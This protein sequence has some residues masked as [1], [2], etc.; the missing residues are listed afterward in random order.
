VEIPSALQSGEG[1]CQVVHSRCSKATQKPS[2]GTKWERAYFILLAKQ[3][4]W[5]VSCAAAAKL[6]LQFLIE[7]IIAL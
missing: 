7:H 4:G 5:V 6:K 1:F 2:W 3:R